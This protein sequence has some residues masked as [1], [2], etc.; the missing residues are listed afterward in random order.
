MKLQSSPWIGAGPKTHCNWLRERAE[1]YCTLESCISPLLCIVWLEEQ[2]VVLLH[3]LLK[4]Q[5]FA[6]RRLQV[7]L[8]QFEETRNFASSIS[9]PHFPYGLH[10]IIS[11]PRN[12]LFCDGF[13]FLTVV[14][15]NTIIVSAFHCTRIW[16]DAKMMT[17]RLTYFTISTLLDSST[18]LV[19]YMLGTVSVLLSGQVWTWKTSVRYSQSFLVRD[20]FWEGKISLGTTWERIYAKVVGKNL[21]LRKSSGNSQT[22]TKTSSR[23]KNTI[24]FLLWLELLCHAMRKVSFFRTLN[25]CERP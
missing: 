13:N 14:G 16:S 9:E 17:L 3:E 12:D 10:Q 1:M 21:M 19:R 2:W 4:S 22:I 23:Y 18:D 5:S 24:L 7:F 11:R 6:Q 15:G 20:H 25:F 8:S